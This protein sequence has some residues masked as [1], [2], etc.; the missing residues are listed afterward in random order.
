MTADPPLPNLWPGNCF[1]C[2]PRNPHGLKLT[3]FRTPEGARTGCLLDTHLCGMEGIA[4]GG[5]VATLLDE[6][7]AW[8]VI[9]HAGRL[10]FTTDMNIRFVRP[11]PTGR[12]LAVEAQMV[13]C[14]TKRARTRASVASE[15]GDK[16]A[17]AQSNWTLMSPQVAARFTG[18]PKERLEAFVAALAPPRAE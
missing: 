18:L 10:G 3:F 8:A 7:A 13:E 12:L 4:H 14:G 11:V 6:V 2:S 16:L 15:L 17:E 9:V 1:G 5:I